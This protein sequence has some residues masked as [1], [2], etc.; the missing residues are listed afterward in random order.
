MFSSSEKDLMWFSLKILLKQVYQDIA[1]V[2]KP[3]EYADLVASSSIP[4]IEKLIEK[5]EAL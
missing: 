4:T 3:E 5:L 1:E 2:G